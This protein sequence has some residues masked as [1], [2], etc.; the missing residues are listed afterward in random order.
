M[1]NKQKVLIVSSEFPPEPGG[2][3]N[4]AY[5]IAK[6]LSMNNYTV[7]V[8]CDQRSKIS[9]EKSLFLKLFSIVLRIVLSS[10]FFGVNFSKDSIKIFESIFNSVRNSIVFFNY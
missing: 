1:I 6:Q 2:I 3:G 4:H 10:L 9:N 7:T 8:V 5:N